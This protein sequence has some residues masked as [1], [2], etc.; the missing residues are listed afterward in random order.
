MGASLKM[1][2]CAFLFGYEIEKKRICVTHKTDVKTMLR[3]VEEQAWCKRSCL[4][5]SS[6]CQ[7]EV[8]QRLHKKK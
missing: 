4:E 3:Q 8:L 6:A 7:S 2:D 1:L 5:P